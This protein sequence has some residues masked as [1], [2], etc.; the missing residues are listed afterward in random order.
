MVKII[1][2]ILR[3]N[4]REFQED[5]DKVKGLVGRVQVDVIDGV[6]ADNK[7]VNPEDLEV[8]DTVVEWDWHLMVDRPEKWVKRCVRGGTGRVFAHI[9]RMNDVAGYIAET[10]VAGMGVGLAL[11][12]ETDVDRLEEYVYDLDAVLLMSVKAG[13]QGQEFDERVLSKIA[14]VR[15]M[16]SDIP[17][18][19]DGGLGVSEI[20]RCVAAEWAEQ[21]R[22][23]EL[24]RNFLD[25]E[26][27]VGGEL[28]RAGDVVAKLE[29]LR[30]LE[31]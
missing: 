14:S 27:A 16:R 29:Q 12:L 5:F 7:T 28:L 25:M 19:V 26:F 17:I 18:V 30:N 11:D 20:K 13:F 23:E 15:K 24:D 8:I 9:E 2:A 4:L 10:Q 3:P 1:P 6:F 22:E 31:E 21:I